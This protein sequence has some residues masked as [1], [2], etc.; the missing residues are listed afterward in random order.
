MSGGGKPNPFKVLAEWIGGLTAVVAA[1]MALLVAVK[2]LPAV[3][4]EACLAF[5]YCSKPHAAADNASPPKSAQEQAPPP[6]AL[7]PEAQDIR[8]PPSSPLA[9]IV[10]FEKPNLRPE[11]VARITRGLPPGRYDVVRE[12]CRANCNWTADVVFV[13]PGKAS[14]QQVKEVLRA[15]KSASII[16]KSVQQLA[17]TNS[18]VQ[19]GN[20]PDSEDW[21]RSE[22]HMSP[23]LHFESVANLTGN[24]FW[25]TAANGQVFCKKPGETTLYE[26]CK[27][28]A[29]G[30][31]RPQ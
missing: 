13:D 25:Q 23:I 7:V 11:D 1:L 9:R 15:L 3:W 24:Q 2:G 31:A 12:A 6:T 27:F 22:F 29:N 30:I 5:G 19:L 28:D 18:L 20:I 4:Q 16:V 10:A 21:N 26:G 8:P 14:V 17:Q